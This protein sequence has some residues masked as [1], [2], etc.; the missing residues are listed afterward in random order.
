MKCNWHNIA[1]GAIE[2]YYCGQIFIA[3]IT[4][5]TCSTRK[6]TAN[7]LKECQEHVISINLYLT[8]Y[9]TGH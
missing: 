6:A 3:K 2:I 4:S 1:H 5:C 8:M 9:I 7:L